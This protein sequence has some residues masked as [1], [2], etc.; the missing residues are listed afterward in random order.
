MIL[1][2]GNMWD[3]YETSN[4]FIFTGNSSVTMRHTLVMGRGMASQVRDKIKLSAKSFG[5]LIL[6]NSDNNLSKYGLLFL[7]KLAQKTLGVFQ[8]KYHYKDKAKLSLIKFSTKKLTKFANEH[9]TKRFD[10]NFPGI[11]YGGLKRKNVLPII[12]KLPD[13]VHIW[14][15]L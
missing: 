13:N 11:G 12:K 8:V 3:V 9:K 1:H 6:Y 5:L 10:M 15:Y 2:K 7:N 4:Y 14:S